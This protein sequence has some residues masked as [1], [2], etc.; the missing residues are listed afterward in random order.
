M[1][2]PA[3]EPSATMPGLSGG[4]AARAPPASPGFDLAAVV[5]ASPRWVYLAD[6]TQS[7]VYED[8]SRE[9]VLKVREA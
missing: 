2:E 5:A 7:T 1:L 3:P 4:P 8:E 6:G 9:Y